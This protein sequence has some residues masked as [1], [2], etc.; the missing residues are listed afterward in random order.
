[1]T[2]PTTRRLIVTG[3][4]GKQ[5]GALISALLSKPKQPLEIYAVTRN[6]TSPSAQRLAAKPNVT[7]IEGNF[8]DPEAIFRQVKDPWG[9]FSVTMPMD[10]VKEEKE[11]KA[12]TAA[13]VKAGV[14]HI[15][16]TGTDRGKN[17]ET[18]ETTVPHFASKFHIEKDIEEKAKK[19]GGKL[20]YTFLR[21]VAFL[22]NMTNDFMGKA[23][24][25]MWKL[26]GVDNKLQM[27]AT[28]DIGKV[29][30]EAFL[31]AESDEYKNKAVPLAGDDFTPRE[32]A[33]VF[34]EVTGQEL[35][36]TFSFVG[37]VLKWLLHK[38]LGLMFN[39]FKSDGFTVEIPELRRKYPYLKDFRTWVETESAW[40]KKSQ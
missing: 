16:F 1:M 18:D 23:F 6:K 19:S 12:V 14:K 10:H 13:A 31:N 40:A 11:G 28:S 25:S 3:A 5:G 17:S 20:T 21:P 15:V 34:K 36:T 9:I 39:W 38:Q 27:I 35:P 29:A 8:S 37:V 33:K 7:L 22:D 26:N 32:A 2:T 4:T 24:V 30:A